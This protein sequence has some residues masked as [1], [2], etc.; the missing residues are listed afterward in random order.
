MGTNS[1]LMVVVSYMFRVQQ[2]GTVNMNL[3]LNK[4]YFFKKST[5]FDFRTK[6]KGKFFLGGFM[7]QLIITWICRII[8]VVIAVGQEFSI[9]EKNR[10]TLLHT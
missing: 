3:R 2:F 10:I 4:L 7:M 8:V 6:D 9:L 5:N 1:V